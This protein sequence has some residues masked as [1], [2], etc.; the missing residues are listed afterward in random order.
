MSKTAFGA[1]SIVA[2]PAEGDRIHRASSI[3]DEQLPTCLRG[4]PPFPVPQL[5]PGRTTAPGLVSSKRAFSVCGVLWF[6]SAV[7]ETRAL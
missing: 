5:Y 6:R 7:L 4:L 1:S 2:V 3:S